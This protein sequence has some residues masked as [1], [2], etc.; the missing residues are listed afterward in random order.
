[1]KV[2]TVPRV[3]EQKSPYTEEASASAP[4]TCSIGT[5]ASAG[6]GE[7]RRFGCKFQ[8]PKQQPI[9]NKYKI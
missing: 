2:K 1:M 5:P 7:E 4:S 9:R 6:G 3:R 8:A